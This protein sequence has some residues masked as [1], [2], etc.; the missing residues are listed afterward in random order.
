[1]AKVLF[2]SPL[3]DVK[4]FEQVGFYSIDIEILRDLGHEVIVVN[5]L[6][7]V[8]SRRYDILFAYFYTWS[9]LAAIIAR[10]KGSRVILTGGADLL[11]KS[12][13]ISYKK[14]LLHRWFF[15]LGHLFSTK[16]LAVSTTDLKNFTQLVGS[17]KIY[18]VPHSVDTSKYTASRIQKQNSFLTIGGMVTEANVRRKGMDIAVKLISELRYRKLN[19]RLIIAGTHGPGAYALLKLVDELELS[20]AVEFKF[21]ISE[22]E[23]INLLQSSKYYLQLSEFEGF[24][25]AALE[26]LS[27]GSC[28]VHSGRGGLMDFMGQYGLIQKWPLNI[29]NIADEVIEN[30][31]CF[32]NNINDIDR[33]HEY[34]VQKFSLTMRREALYSIIEN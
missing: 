13:N 17:S 30:N 31:L 21:N 23:K 15:R 33:R 7:E 29:K 19:V 20:D 10:L 12:F 5:K 1:M 24:G 2:Y 22:P 34:V 18:L 6:V 8:F 25:L 26:A 27:C 32:S 3:I 9:S 11:D 16:I 14:L 28:V 4:L